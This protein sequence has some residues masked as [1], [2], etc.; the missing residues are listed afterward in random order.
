M[1]DKP[2]MMGISNA[3]AGDL[4]LGLI[5]PVSGSRVGMLAYSKI[6]CVSSFVRFLGLS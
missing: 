6:Y 2:L 3:L 5:L 4:R 1:I